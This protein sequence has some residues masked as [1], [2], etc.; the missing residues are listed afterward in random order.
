MKKPEIKGFPISG[1]ITPRGGGNPFFFSSKHIHRQK[2][3]GL[4][5]FFYFL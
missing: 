3:A 2:A 4:W 5:L 1:A